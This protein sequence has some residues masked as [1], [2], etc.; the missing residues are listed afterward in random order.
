MSVLT[1]YRESRPQGW[2]TSAPSAS[3]FEFRG[4][5]GDEASLGEEP[6]M[7]ATLEPITVE[8]QA[9]LRI[10]VADDNEMIGA[11]VGGLL[12][13]LGHS[14]DVVSN[15]RDAVDSAALID[16]DAVFLD[17]RM[18]QMDGYEV[19]HLMRHWHA[20]GR[21]P[22]IIG[23]SGESPDRELYAAAGMDDFLLKPVRLA[24]LVHALEDRGLVH[25]AG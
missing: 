15:G 5:H 7:P 16:F 24:D 20:G 9:P 13:S 19:A 18:P 14:V 10:L 22:R 21:S 1:D 3:P 4:R 2:R 12:Q 6:M 23:F 11:A 25:K 17:I 8:V